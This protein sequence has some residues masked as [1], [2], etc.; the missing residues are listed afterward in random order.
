[1][2]VLFTDKHVV[3][4]DHVSLNIIEVISALFFI[5]LVFYVPVIAPFLNLVCL[6][7]SDDLSV[8]CFV[9]FPW[10]GCSWNLC[11]PVPPGQATL[12]ICCT[13]LTVTSNLLRMYS[14]LLPHPFLVPF[15]VLAGAREMFWNLAC[16]KTSSS[17]FSLQ[18]WKTLLGCLQHR[19]W[20]ADTSL[21][22]DLSHVT[23]SFSLEAFTVFS[24]SLVFGN[25]IIICLLWVGVSFFFPIN[26]TWHLQTLVLQFHE[27]SWIISLKII[28]STSSNFSISGPLLHYPDLPF[29]V[30]SPPPSISVSFSGLFCFF[31]F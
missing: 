10:R 22:P 29:V 8:F 25:F 31:L 3:C 5:C 2:Q 17:P 1:M 16:Q 11:C 9:F 26:W 27:M 6:S 15:L 7:P 13:L 14:A 24:L 21:I 19:C 12:W 20:E 30:Y 28:F 18:I 23:C 4:H